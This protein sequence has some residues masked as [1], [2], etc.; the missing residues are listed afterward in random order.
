MVAD[1]SFWVGSP[2]LRRDIG[3]YTPVVVTADDI[4]ALV[5]SDLADPQL[6]L[7]QGRV[8]VIS[9]KNLDDDPS[10]IVIGTRAEI[11]EAHQV[12]DPPHDDQLETIAALFDTRASELGA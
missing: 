7:E 8:Q 3:G 12:A 6:I 2:R 9:G 5:E 10:A 4:R 1:S 11:Y